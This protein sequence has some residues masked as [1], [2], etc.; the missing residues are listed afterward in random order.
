VGRAFARTA[1]RLHQVQSIDGPCVAR[2][3]ASR[4]LH[5]EYDAP[6]ERL[7]QNLVTLSSQRLDKGLLV[8]ADAARASS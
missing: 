5:D 1:P 7:D 2:H 3:S 6:A 8:I 4:Q